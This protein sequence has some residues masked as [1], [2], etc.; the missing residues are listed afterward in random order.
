MLVSDI[1]VQKGDLT[2]RNH[3]QQKNCKTNHKNSQTR[4]ILITQGLVTSLHKLFMCSFIIL[5]IV[6]NANMSCGNS[7][8]ILHIFYMKTPFINF[9][10]KRYTFPVL[11][12]CMCQ[13]F[14]FLVSQTIPLIYSYI[15]LC[16]NHIKVHDC[17]RPIIMDNCVVFIRSH[18]SIKSRT[19]LIHY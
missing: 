18:L 12:E 8:A 1:L 10:N 14:E 9:T 7:T 3:Q 4:C 6:H 16:E 2:H 13:D 5:I 15:R 17:P 19:T 11:H